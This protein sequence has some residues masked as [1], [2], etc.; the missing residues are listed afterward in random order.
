MSNPAFKRGSIQNDVYNTLR[1][2]IISLE[3]KPGT[4][5]STQ[6]TASRLGVS[7]TP[8]RE[9]FLHLQREDLL[10]V[11]PQRGT[12]VSYINLHRM[13]Q[14]RF[15]REAV[16]VDN[17]PQFISV[18]QQENLDYLHHNVQLQQE[19]LEQN[20]ARDYIRLDNEFHIYAMQCTGQRLARTIVGELNGHYDRLRLLTVWE[21]NIARN[22]A[23]EHVELLKL[24]KNRDIKA[25]QQLLR[26]HL[27][28][29]KE[30]E[31]SLIRKWPDFF[32]KEVRD[33]VLSQA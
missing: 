28:A 4:M 18:L 2:E 8:V 33:E 13:Y 27:Q 17:L 23:V 5:L 20:R 22:A 31:Q 11:A 10:D 14:E 26:R 24:F 32:A 29:L 21:G 12:M 15:I 19:A 7:R 1:E 6:E 9:A 25:A 16:E 30:Q 3:L